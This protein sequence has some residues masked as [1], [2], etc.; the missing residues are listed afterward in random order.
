MLRFFTSLCS[1]QNDS[2]WEGYKIQEILVI[3]SVGKGSPS[4]S[5]FALSTEILR[6]VPLYSE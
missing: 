1:V 4:S 3:L 5:L 6:P 2:G